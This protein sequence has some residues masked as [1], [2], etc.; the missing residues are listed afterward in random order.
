MVQETWLPIGEGGSRDVATTATLQ[1]VRA[2]TEGPYKTRMRTQLKD[3]QG[4]TT[5]NFTTLVPAWDLVLKL[6]ESM[7]RNPYIIYRY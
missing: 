2:K 1:N 7:E 3:L 4:K 5:A 6:R